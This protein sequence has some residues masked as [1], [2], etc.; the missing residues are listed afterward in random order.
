MVFIEVCSRYDIIKD[1]PKLIKIDG[2]EL[3][4]F[5]IGGEFFAIDNICPHQSG[6]LSEGEIHEEEIYCPRHCWM[7][8]IKSG[9]CLNV[10]A[11]RVNTY[12]VKVEN[13]KIL[14]DL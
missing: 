10:P 12:K 9:Q 1:S 6:S 14:V 13:E 4:L 11:A 7:F 2:K 3:S 8:N 5:N